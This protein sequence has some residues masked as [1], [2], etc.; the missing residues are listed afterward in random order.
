[1]LLEYHGNT[2]K[3]ERSNQNDGVKFHD[4]C[5]SDIVIM[6]DGTTATQGKLYR[7]GVCFMNRPL[8]LKD[9]VHVHGFCKPTDLI[10][11]KNHAYTRIGLTNKDPDEIRRS[12]SKMEACGSTLEKVEIFQ[13][14]NTEIS[15]EEFHLSICLRRNAT[16]SIKLNGTRQVHHRY[17][18]VST[19]H[20]LW[21]V[22]QPY[23]IK[24]IK[25]SNTVK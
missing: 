11:H 25:I 17:P 13:E 21:L 1:M 6:G 3:T 20:P 10:R 22:I 16:L 24:S 5:D 19:A 4:V 18:Q 15:F 14:D 12:E 23:G 2:Q 8:T 7:S 9:E